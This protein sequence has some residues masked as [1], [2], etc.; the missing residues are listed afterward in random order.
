[1]RLLHTYILLQ[2]LLVEEKFEI[3]K[4]NETK[5]SESHNE[6]NPCTFFHLIFLG[7]D[8]RIYSGF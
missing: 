2:S 5:W 6:R 4:Y 3:S 8:G 7:Y 1:M